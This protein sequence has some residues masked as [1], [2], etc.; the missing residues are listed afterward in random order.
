MQ[1]PTNLNSTKRMRLTGAFT[2]MITRPKHGLPLA[3]HHAVLV[4][5]RPLDWFVLDYGPMGLRVLTLAEFAADRPIRITRVRQGRRAV[6]RALTRARRFKVAELAGLAPF[7]LAK[8]NCEH[9]ANEILDGTPESGQA[10]AA[11][12]VLG[13]GFGVWLL[14]RVIDDST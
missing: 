12:F 3:T 11:G 8:L 13:M 14:S 9:V 1:M 4:H 10:H 2:A 6:H 5:A 7:N